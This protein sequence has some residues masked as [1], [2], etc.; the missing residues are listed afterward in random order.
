M[1]FARLL[2]MMLVLVLFAGLGQTVAADCEPRSA[3]DWSC[4]KI[5]T[6]DDERFERLLDRL[7]RLPGMNRLQKK[8]DFCEI[9]GRAKAGG[10]P[11]PA[12][13]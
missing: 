10:A 6:M 12:R 4:T 7:H 11:G 13:D 9:W 1:K 3:G 8:K 2:A 5:L